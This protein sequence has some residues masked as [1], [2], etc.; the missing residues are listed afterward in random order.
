MDFSTSIPGVVMPGSAE[1][2][3]VH[4]GDFRGHAAMIVHLRRIALGKSARG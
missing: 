3:A 4:F 1:V 2:A